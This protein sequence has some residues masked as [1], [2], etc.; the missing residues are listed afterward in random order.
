VIID[1]AC[2]DVPADKADKKEGEALDALRR[3]P[4]SI[5]PSRT[6]A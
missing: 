2:E 4:S 6:I 3:N 5:P 1:V